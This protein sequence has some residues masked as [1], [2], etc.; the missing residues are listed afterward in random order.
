MTTITGAGLIESTAR[1]GSGEVRDS[2]LSPA[3]HIGLQR[4]GRARLA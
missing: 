4:M 2:V 1:L 3:S